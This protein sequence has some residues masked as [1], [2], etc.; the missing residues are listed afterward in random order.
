MPTT[1]STISK[2]NKQNHLKSIT[3]FLAAIK[4]EF[5]FVNIHHS[6]FL[7]GL[8]IDHGH[9]LIDTNKLKHP[10]DILHEAGHIAAMP[11]NQRATLCDNVELYGQGPAEEMAAIAWSWAA[12]CAINL[13]ARELFHAEGYRG[14]SDNYLHA[15][16]NNGGF[17]YPMLIYWGLAED[18]QQPNGYP[19]MKH[20]L[21][22]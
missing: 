16:E 13:P 10:G 8:L 14:A 2:L 11:T 6:T 21:R 4:I 1:Y 3:M 20:W 7:P 5:R 17:G 19:K 18:P 12:C 9:L 15:F 22:Q